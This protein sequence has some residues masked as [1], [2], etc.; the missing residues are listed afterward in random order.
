MRVLLVED[1]HTLARALKR[2]LEAEGLLTDLEYDGQTGLEYAL[3]GGYDVVVLDIM[4]PRLNGYD[5]CRQMR[6]SNVWTPVLMLSAKDGE[7]D[8]VDAFDLGA[9]D[10]LVK[11]FSFPVLVA[12]LRSLIRRGVVARPPV[13]AAGDLHLDPATRVVGRGDVHISLTPREFGLLHYLMRHKGMV[14]SKLDILQAVWDVHHDGA[15]N[16]VEVYVALSAKEGGRAVRAAVHPDGSWL[17]LPAREQRRLSFMVSPA[18]PWRAS[19]RTRTAL[20]ASISLAVVLGIVSVVG[21]LYQRHQLTD[22]VAL[23]AEERAQTVATTAAGDVPLTTSLGGEMSLVQVIDADGVVAASSPSLSGAPAIVRPAEVTTTSRLLVSGLVEGEADRYLVIAV[24][25]AD[26]G[27]VVAAQSLETVQAATSSTIRLLVVG[28]LLLLLMVA[29]LTFVL[30]GRALRPV[31]ALRAQAA[32]ITAADLSARLPVVE[33]GDEI[34][35]LSVTLNEML[36]RLQASADVQ[37]RFVAD[38]SHE[39]RSPVATIRTLHEVGA[40]LGDEADWPTVSDDVLTETARLEHLVSDLLLLARSGAMTLASAE[41]LDLS[42]LVRGE[43]SRARSVAIDSEIAPGVLVLGRADALARALRNLLDNAE[44]HARAQILI[45]LSTDGAVASLSV[46]DDGDGIALE[47]RDR[48]FDRFVRLDEARARDDGGSGLGLAIARH[49][50]HE[51][52]GTI[53]LVAGNGSGAAFVIELPRADI[54]GRSGT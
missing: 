9:D 15:D 1:E 16:L 41:V 23:V 43:A 19:V 54:D 46:Q 8:Q 44:R 37:R 14:V 34:E 24:P 27:A 11:P 35:R 52:H 45:K 36:A 47:D 20:A 21:V 25:T 3:A 28:D 18:R 22:G 12:R 50:V 13:L 6:A 42:T 26:G 31:D 49:L 38:A 7:Y 51:N 40:A 30:V 17:R 53:R 5:I 33:T 4:L 10:Y 39:L 48:I 29:G 32:E 2:G